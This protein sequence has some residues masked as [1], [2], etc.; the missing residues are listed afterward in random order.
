MML[1]ADDIGFAYPRS[2]LLF[3]G[4]D[5]RVPGGAMVALTGRSG[6][7]KST[8]L[9]MLGLM[10][11][12]TEG[13]IVVDGKVASGL[14]DAARARLRAER[15]GFVFQD[16]ALDPTRT[17]LDNVVEPALYRGHDPRAVRDAAG[18]LLDE[19][20]VDV[21]VDRVP[22]QVSGGQAQRI[23]LARALLHRPSI[24]LADEPTGNLDDE[25]SDTVLRTL[26]SQA[27]RGAAVVVSTHDD[28]AR[29]HCDREHAL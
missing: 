11:T 26:R 29:E 28:R 8:L 3:D 10:V 18:D 20:G 16:A 1:V 21:P 27:E 6:T 9:Y 2:A 14:N 4:L 13:R 17:V 19:L 23:A 22:G 24:V 12:P 7:G 5:L 15:F 25:S